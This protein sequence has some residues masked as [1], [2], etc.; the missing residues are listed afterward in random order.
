MDDFFPD[1]VLQDVMNEIENLLP[2]TV[3]GEVSCGYSTKLDLNIKNRKNIWLDDHFINNRD[4][5]VILK[6]VSKLIWCDE[7][8]NKYKNP[9]NGVFKSYQFTTHDNTSLSVYNNDNYYREHTDIG[10]GLI[11]TSNIMIGSGFKG[12]DFKLQDKVIKFKNNR[13]II[14]ESNRT[15][16][17]TNVITDNNFKNWRY[18]IQYWAKIK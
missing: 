6:Y 7:L 13:L 11:L 8:R 9:I 2:F 15:H 12:G 18:S 5:S 17:V 10:D 16:S 14:F 3:Q 1:S 4:G